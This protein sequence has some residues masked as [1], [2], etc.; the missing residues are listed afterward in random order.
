MNTASRMESTGVPGRIQVSSETAALL[1]DAGKQNWLIQR[2]NKVEAKGKGALTTFFLEMDVRAID[3][4]SQASNRSGLGSATDELRLR[5]IGNA[6]E[7]ERKKRVAECTVEVLAKVLKSI[8]T[9][10]QIV[11]IKPDHGDVIVKLEV[12][13]LSQNYSNI[14]AIDEV[15][16]MVELPGYKANK[17]ETNDQFELDDKIVMELRHYVQTIASLYNDNPFH[18]FDHANHVVMSVNKLLSRI[19]APDLDVDTNGKM[20]YDH[21]YGITSDPLTW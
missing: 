9:Q 3:T 18:N 15:A 7:I 13:S 21:T 8:I 11:G 16:E 14:M 19:N 20:L 1:T 6:Q 17:Q 5:S 2:E 4:A 10:R 12:Q